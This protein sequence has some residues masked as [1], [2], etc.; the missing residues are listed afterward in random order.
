[1]GR[2]QRLPLEQALLGFLMQE[3]MHGYD[4]HQRIEVELGE[5]WYMGISNVYSTLKRLEQSGWIES[6]LMPQESRPSRKVYRITPTGEQSFLDWLRQPV[7]IMQKMRVE[8]PTKLYFFRTLGL[9][10]VSDLITAQE[11]VCQERIERLEQKAAQCAPHDLN[12]LVFDFR[13]RQIEAM[14]DWLHACREDI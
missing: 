9:D 10:G 12:R 2:R 11:S 13:R 6:T 4:L 5:I 1:M 8:F 3:P 7:P 14:I